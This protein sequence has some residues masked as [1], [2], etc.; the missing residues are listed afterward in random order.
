MTAAPYD[1]DAESIW[2][3]FLARSLPA[4]GLRAYVQRVAG[5]ADGEYRRGELFLVHGPTAG[6][7]STFLGRF[8]VRGET[9][10][11]RPTSTFTTRRGR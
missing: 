5:Y 7:K 1:P 9:T 10:R 3:G 6:G 4:E 2:E 8:D 11:R